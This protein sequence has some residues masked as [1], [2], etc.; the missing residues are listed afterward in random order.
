M[1]PGILSE[2]NNIP[3]NQNLAP[4]TV[5]KLPFRDDHE[6][7]KHSLYADLYEK[8][9]KSIVR[10]RTYQKWINRGVAKGDKI[11]NPSQFYV[12]KSGDTLWDI[13]K[14]TGV[15]I[16][17]IIRSNYSLVKRRM[18]LPGDKLAIK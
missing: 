16:N 18:I 2:L 9:R 13:A 12:V 10:K 6:H 11:N 4:K 3:T 5:V 14:K 7:K 17:T 15:S 8:P 1:K